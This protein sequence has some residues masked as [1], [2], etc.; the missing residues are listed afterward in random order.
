MRYVAALAALFVIVVVIGLVYHSEPLV[1]TPRRSCPPIPTAGPAP[2][3]ETA[4][5]IA[6]RQSQ[7]VDGRVIKVRRGHSADL[8]IILGDAYCTIPTANNDAWGVTIRGHYP[9]DP[10]RLW[11]ETIVVDMATGAL[12]NAE[13]REVR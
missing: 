4:T 5:R 13:A 8:A 2:D 9:G 11:D 1:Y 6:T 10:K 7:L 3:A 12:I